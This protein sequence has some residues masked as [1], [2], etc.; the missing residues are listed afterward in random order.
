MELAF[1]EKKMLM[2]LLMK[3]GWET[4]NR[5]RAGR[6]DLFNAAFSFAYE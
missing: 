5:S 1:S 4:G 2:K 6:G 3:S